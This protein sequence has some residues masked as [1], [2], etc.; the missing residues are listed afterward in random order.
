MKKNLFFMGLIALGMSLG[1]TSCSSSDDSTASGAITEE[2]AQNLDYSSELANAWGNYAMNVTN[3]L[4]ADATALY[5]AW[6]E[7]YEGGAPFAQQFKSHA[8]GSGYQSAEN[9]VEE[10]FQGCIDIAGEVGTAKIGEPVDYWTQGQRNKALYAVE[11]WYSWHSRDDYKNNILSIANSFLGK[12][13]ESNVTLQTSLSSEANANSIYAI[14]SGKE[15]TRE[16]TAKVWEDICAA[17]HAIDDIPQPFRNNIGST[18]AATAMEACATLGEDLET[19]QALATENLTDDE[20]QLI[21]NQFV[22]GVALVTY[23]VLKE[24]VEALY[25]A[26]QNLKNNPTN[27]NFEAAAAAWLNARQPWESSEAFLFG[28]VDKLGLDPNM[29]S[30]PLDAVGIYNLLQSQKWEEMNWSDGDDD[31][32][33]EAAQS[34]RGF[35]T[36]EFLIFK[37]GTPR[38]VN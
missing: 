29:D 28:P 14:C 17:W 8:A 26:V 16:Q 3:L 18:E 10:I 13:L 24:N 31:K 19:L 32:S 20:C 21:V 37:N 7:S 4:K 23:K 15:E 11:S 25:T 35:H 9:C 12:V 36:L 1:M 2:Q 30:W 5:A 6:S 34:L 33:V 27:D 22:D 38:T